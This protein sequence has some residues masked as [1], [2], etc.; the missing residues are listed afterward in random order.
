[1]S[2]FDTVH[3]LQVPHEKTTTNYACVAVANKYLHE[4]LQGSPLIDY[5][6]TCRPPTLRA[7][8]LGHRQS[9]RHRSPPP[10]LLPPR[11]WSF[12]SEGHPPRIS[13][14]GHG[15]LAQHAPRTLLVIRLA[16]P[17]G[18][19]TMVT[20]SPRHTTISQKTYIEKQHP[21]VSSYTPSPT[22]LPPPYKPPHLLPTPLHHFH[23]LSSSPSPLPTPRAPS[24]RTHPPS[25]CLAN[26]TERWSST[27]FSTTPPRPRATPVFLT[28]P[29]RCPRPPLRIQL[30]AG[31]PRLRILLPPTTVVAGPTTTCPLLPSVPRPPPPPRSCPRSTV[32]VPI[33]CSPPSTPVAWRPPSLSQ[34]FRSFLVTIPPRARLMPN[35]VPGPPAFA[36]TR[37]P[38]PATISAGVVSPSTKENTSRGMTSSSMTSSVLTSARSVRRISGQSRICKSISPLRS[39]GRWP[40]SLPPRKTHLCVVHIIHFHGR[41]T[42]EN[43]TC[44]V[45]CYV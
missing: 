10:T 41:M 29:P 25:T 28:P 44:R 5:H 11:R 17:C 42:I 38:A 31:P 39:T 36:R 4:N 18:V 32:L 34:P 20:G 19:T 16:R 37:A 43:V 15:S 23:I 40:C 2:F 26:P 9:H 27:S 8:S 30:A 14:R 24:Y 3:G 12:W 7:K 45:D 6:P 21:F 35:P 22:R 33:Q 13:G 1:M